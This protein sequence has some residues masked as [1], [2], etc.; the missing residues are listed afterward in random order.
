MRLSFVSGLSSLVGSVTVEVKQ[1]GTQTRLSIS[2]TRGF[3]AVRELDIS[4]SLI[5]CELF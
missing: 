2:K 1:T 4:H 5:A 3:F